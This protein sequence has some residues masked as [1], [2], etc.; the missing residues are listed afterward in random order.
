MTEPLRPGRKV[1][2]KKF[3]ICPLS[4]VAVRAQANHH[5]EMLSQM[6]FGELF[7]VLEWKGLKWLHVRCA[8]DKLEGWV[9]CSQVHLLTGVEFDAYRRNFAFNLDL[10][11]PVFAEDFPMLLPLGARLPG[12]DGLGFQL[13]GETYHFSG[14][15]IAPTMLHPSPEL[16]QKLAKRYLKVPFL[17]GGRTPLG[18]DSAGLV[19]MVLQILGISVPRSATE[20]VMVG[21]VVDFAEE[22]QAGDI[23]FFENSK[24]HIS[25][26]GLLLSA[27][28]IMHVFGYGRIDLLDHFGIYN[29]NSCH[30]THHL[31]L[32][33]RVLPKWM[34]KPAE[35][36]IETEWTSN[37]GMLF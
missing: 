9:D 12:F 26:C 32:I 27:T 23:A 30:Y 24:G 37:Q 3:G 6:L 1:A 16:I 21:E 15:A 35:N 36:K 20:Q 10:M 22:A 19:Q 25:H 5:S 29:R 28:E 13:A 31:R 17:Q 2:D 8:L 14:Q 33:K 34:L 18:I 11:H 4:V 7:E